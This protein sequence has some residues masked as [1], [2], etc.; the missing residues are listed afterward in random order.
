MDYRNTDMSNVINEYVRN[1]RYKTVLLLRYCTGETYERIA[2]AVSY[3]PQHVKYICKTHRD[4]L[5]RHL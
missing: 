4:L 2:E 5:M 3:S 1:P